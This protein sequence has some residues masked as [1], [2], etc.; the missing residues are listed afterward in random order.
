MK[1]CFVAILGLSLSVSHVAAVG[2]YI[3]FKF[4]NHLKEPVTFILG[5][6]RQ[7]ACA[8]VAETIEAKGKVLAG[9]NKNI[10]SLDVSETPIICFSVGSQFEKGKSHKYELAVAGKKKASVKVVR[11]KLG[12]VSLV[13][14]GGKDNVDVT[15]L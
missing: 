10:T 9:K 3:D 6:K 4:E 2:K 1:K 12:D 11:D 7:G 15:R 8:G 13:T 5:N 14:T